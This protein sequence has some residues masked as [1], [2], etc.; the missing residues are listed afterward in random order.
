M[1]TTSPT[2]LSRT[3]P[4]PMPSVDTSATPPA[5]AGLTVLGGAPCRLP[6]ISAE[7]IEHL[8]LRFPTPAPDADPVTVQ[9]AYAGFIE[10]YGTLLVGNM[11]PLEDYTDAE[12]S[13]VANNHQYLMDKIKATVPQEAR[14]GDPYYV[15][16]EQAVKFKLRWAGQ[17]PSVRVFYSRAIHSFAEFKQNLNADLACSQLATEVLNP[18]TNQPKYSV[19]TDV[20]GTDSIG[21][22]RRAV[23][24]GHEFSG[25]DFDAIFDAQTGAI[26]C[27]FID[28]IINAA[29]QESY[30]GDGKPELLPVAT[31]KFFPKMLLRDDS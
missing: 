28:A 8:G 7:R 29:R 30:D 24:N 22:A 25:A 6:Y 12:K 14:D 11:E 16:A 1:Q 19:G 18:Q 13:Y 21:L 23:I 4:Q 10:R 9:D 27:P 3:L 31:E 15:D 20:D 26:D 5:T 17:E 2:L